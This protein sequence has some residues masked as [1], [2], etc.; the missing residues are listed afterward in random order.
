MADYY[1]PTVVEPNIPLADMT[2]LEQLLLTQIFDSETVDDALYFYEEQSTQDMIW[3]DR[4]EVRDALEQS[5]G[6]A[7]RA[8][9]LV[10]NALAKLEPDAEDL[11]LDLSMESWEFLFQDIIR[12]SATITHVTVTTAF[13]CSKMRPDG[14]GGMVT[15][16][17]GE[18]VLSSSTGEMLCS[19][20][21][22]ADY[23]ELACAPGHGSHVVLG[24]SEEEVRGTMV[25]IFETEASPGL[26]E[27]D[28]TDDDIRVACIAA[29][30]G[31]D[32]SH[33]HGELIFAAALRA[34]NTAAERKRAGG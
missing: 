12:R 18:Q 4:G 7:S 29:I 32:L 21:D 27:D 30:E 34:L 16:I 25:E 1:S 13:T 15:M 19:L 5:Q 33:E 28:V 26:V 8:N 6:L 23:G 24:L 22:R 31:R 11:E 20:L 3:L 17:T 9:E 2:P 14:F 10:A